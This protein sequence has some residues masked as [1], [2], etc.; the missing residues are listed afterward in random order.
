[1]PSLVIPHV[2][3]RCSGYAI[4]FAPNRLGY[5]NIIPRDGVVERK[6]FSLTVTRPDYPIRRR[7]G[8]D[9]W[10][11]G[12]PIDGEIAVPVGCSSWNSL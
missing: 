8:Q 6:E 11:G 7:G 9:T 5:R 4:Q 1:M 12:D 2:S 10:T 3:I